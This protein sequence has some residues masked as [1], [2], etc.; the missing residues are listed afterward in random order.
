LNRKV[1]S[2][3]EF[4]SIFLFHLISLQINMANN[5]ATKENHFS[6]FDLAARFPIGFNTKMKKITQSTVLSFFLSIGNSN[7]HP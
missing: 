1:A 7:F 5:N 4:G 3:Q 6:K 2:F